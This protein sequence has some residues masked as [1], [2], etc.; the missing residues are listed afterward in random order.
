MY[1][2]T[3]TATSCSSYGS[4]NLL[5]VSNSLAWTFYRFN[6]TA[7]GTTLTLTFV[8][9]NGP[10]DETAYLDDVSVVDRA[11]PS[12]QLLEN[13]S[14]ENSS[15]NIT[16]WSLWCTTSCTRSGDGGQITTSGC[17]T[18]SGTNCFK[19]HCNSG[20]NFLG[21]AF[22]TTPSSNYSIS[23][24]LFKNGGGAGLFYANVG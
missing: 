22:T 13:P 17:H 3:I 21:Q 12:I 24:W 19:D 18:G 16:G 4:A 8:I 7:T 1:M 14:F 2:Y 10:A 11:A 5:S 20:Y 15:S 6:Y 9:H 23:F